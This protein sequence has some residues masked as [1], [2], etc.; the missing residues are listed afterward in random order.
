MS[1]R[2]VAAL[3][4]A[5]STSLFAGEKA[6]SAAWRATSEDATVAAAAIDELRAAGPS[7][8]ETMQAI[9]TDVA[10][11]DDENLTHRYQAALDRVCAQRDCRAS[12]LYWYTD[13][14]KA[15]AAAQQSHRPILA[16]VLLGHLDDELSCANSRFF[17]TMLYSDPRISALMREHFVLYWKSER[18]VP[19]IT[20]DMGDGRRLETTITGNSAHYLL[21]SDGR[22]LDILP[23][24]HSP[25]AFLARLNDMV[26]LHRTFVASKRDGDALA[27][28]HANLAANSDRFAQESPIYAILNGQ[29]PSAALAAQRAVSKGIV[30]TPILAQL[31]KKTRTEEIH[32][33]MPPMHLDPASIALIQSK[34]APTDDLKSVL[35]HLS[36]SVGEDTLRNELILHRTIHEWFAKA[37]LPFDFEALNSRV[38]REL[39]LTPEEDPWLGLVA[40]NSF[41]GVPNNGIV[42][43]T[44]SAKR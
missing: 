43:E 3:L 11:R 31:D 44:L 1:H 39:F 26:E 41:S 29:L 34:L 36:Q 12:N 10:S 21:D 20:I 17:R 2:Q 25:A 9:A 8:V 13:F 28:Y 15:E 16:L 37:T 18:P 38:Y 5:A 22:P 42:G 4:F 35:E 7:A 24:L 14:A 19:R 23:G 30:E 32:R 27:A 33:A 40:E 6:P